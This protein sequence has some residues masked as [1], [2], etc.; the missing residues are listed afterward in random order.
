MKNFLIGLLVIVIILVV[1]CPAQAQ[2]KRPASLDTAISLVDKADSQRNEA[3]AKVAKAETQVE[4]L[5]SWGVGQWQRAEDEKASKEKYRG[6][7]ISWAISGGLVGALVFGLLGLAIGS[8]VL[9][10]L[11]PDKKASVAIPAAPSAAPAVPMAE[12]PPPAPTPEEIE[13][14]KAVL[15]R[16]AKKPAKARK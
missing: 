9:S 15:A 11:V 4:N 13:E 2:T 7:R 6:S 1:G 10:Y 5:K 16:V 8:G 14:A 12:I 3:L